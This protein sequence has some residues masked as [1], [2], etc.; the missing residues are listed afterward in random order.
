VVVPLDGLGE[1]PMRRDDSPRESGFSFPFFFSLL[2]MTIRQMYFSCEVE[3][4]RASHSYLEIGSS[5]ARRKLLRRA[6]QR[7]SLE[8]LLVR[9]GN[10]SEGILM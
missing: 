6:S 2:Y 1:L 7:N 8:G 5:C 4:P 3:S 9:G 10:F